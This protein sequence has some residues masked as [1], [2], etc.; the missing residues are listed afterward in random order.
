MKNI[1]IVG[2]RRRDA[3]ADYILVRDKF[4][5]VY[6]YGDT[7]VSGGCKQGADRF[8]E[9]FALWY[10]IPITIHRPEP[11]P[12]GSPRWAHTKAN[13]ARNTLIAQDSD[14][15]I[16]CVSEDRKGGTENTIK[17]FKKIHPKNTVILITEKQQKP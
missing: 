6:E 5:E 17:S 12:S 3:E 9:L 16:A 8:A 7:I 14:I 2:S 1:G 13:Y 15:L 10:K 4:L 11:V